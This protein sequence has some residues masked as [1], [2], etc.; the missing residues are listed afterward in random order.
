MWSMATEFP[1]TV[2]QTWNMEVEGTLMYKL[3]RK[4]KVLKGPLKRLNGHRFSNVE[5]EASQAKNQLIKI[6]ELIQKNPTDLKL[7]EEE[8]EAAQWYD[9]MAK[10]RDSFLR[11]KAK[12]QWCADG[13]SNTAY[14]HY[15]IKARRSY[16]KVL[17][18]QDEIG[19]LQTD[20][21]MITKLF[22]DYY[23]SLL[24]SNSDV[25]KVH[26]PTVALGPLITT[27]HLNLL[28]AEV[29]DGEIKVA[30]FG[31]QG[32]KSP[33]PDGYTSQFFQNSWDVVG[34]MYAKQ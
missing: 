19:M 21:K 22:E 16:N 26:A 24:G 11:Q 2:A 1:T 23:V 12:A 5:L 14:F 28:D 9:L 8:K 7:F 3:V 25:Q 33:G 13:D 18:I 20:H 15:C 17:A 32:N 4:L 31:F 30:M 6:Q 34:E 29:T 10:A 27:A